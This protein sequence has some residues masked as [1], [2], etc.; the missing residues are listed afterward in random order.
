M[1]VP[2]FRALQAM[3]SSWSASARWAP[4]QSLGS[5]AGSG[6]AG[7]VPVGLVLQVTS[8]AWPAAA[9][10]RRPG[11]VP[12]PPQTREQ[13]GTALEQPERENPALR[14]LGL[15]ARLACCGGRVIGGI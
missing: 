12:R 10:R 4:P 7:Q 14:R 2:V 11:R 9:A 8:E 15:S 1:L 13:R 6:G 3:V 5:L